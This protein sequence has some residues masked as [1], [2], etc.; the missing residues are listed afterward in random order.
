[1]EYL[2]VLGRGIAYAVAVFGGL[3]LFALAC[4][5]VAELVLG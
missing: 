3:A 5:A 1:M 4:G 2:S